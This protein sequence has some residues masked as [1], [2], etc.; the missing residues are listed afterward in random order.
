MVLDSVTNSIHA[1]L[2]SVGDPL[3]PTACATSPTLGVETAISAEA[4]TLNRGGA[5]MAISAE[6]EASTLEQ[7]RASILV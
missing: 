1:R 5:K 6:A 4:V 7:R 3:F 2:V